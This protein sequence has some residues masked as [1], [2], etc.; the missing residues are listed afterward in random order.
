[1]SKG[2]WKQ[3]IFTLLDWCEFLDTYEFN[4]AMKEAYAPI[5]FRYIL[6]GDSSTLC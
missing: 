5:M 4:K 6:A 1:M 3:P 2:N